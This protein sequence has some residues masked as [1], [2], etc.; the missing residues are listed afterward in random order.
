MDATPSFSCAPQQR[1]NGCRLAR[2]IAPCLAVCLLWMTPHSS[3]GF[4]PTISASGSD[5]LAELQ[6]Q[7]DAYLDEVRHTGRT[8]PAKLA[9]LEQR[10]R[11][12]AEGQ[13]GSAVLRTRVEVANLL[14]I[15]G[16]STE[17]AA[18]FQAVGEEA[19]RHEY[20]DV[21]FDAWIGVIR[22]N[23]A[24]TQNEIDHAYERAIAAAGPT[25]TRRQRHD[26]A[27]FHAQILEARGEP[28][29]AL[30]ESLESLMNAER[31]DD[32][33]FDRLTTADILFDIA[34]PCDHGKMVD[35]RT[36]SD[37]EKDGWEAC[38]RAVAAAERAYGVTL[39][40]AQTQGWGSEFAT[41]QKPA[42][43]FLAVQINNNART[44][45]DGAGGGAGPNQ[46][47]LVNESFSAGPLSPQLAQ[48][49]GAKIQGAIA[50]GSDSP[51]K[52]Y[53][54][55]LNESIQGNRAEALPYFKQAATKL[56]DERKG[57]F[58]PLRRGTVI[59]GRVEI[60]QDLALALLANGDQAA[61]FDVFE[62]FRSRGLN[63]LSAASLRANT[64]RERE[65]LAALVGI[66]AAEN[67]R[68]VRIRERIVSGGDAAL[69]TGEHRELD[70]DRAARSRL[71]SDAG[72]RRSFSN[73]EF[74][75]ARLADLKRASKLSG[76]PVVLYWTT[77][78]NVVVWIVSPAGESRVRTVLLPD[79]AL[80]EL[81]RRVLKSSSAADDGVPL[82]E[83]AA[84]QLHRHLLGP[85]QDLLAGSR[86]MIVP[87]GALTDLPF[88]ALLDP[89]TKRYAVEKWAISYAPNATIA[90]QMLTQEAPIGRDVRAIVDARLNAIT[91]EVDRIS[92]IPAFKV[93]AVD[94]DLIETSRLA[95]LA[96]EANIVHVLVHG[97]ANAYEPTLFQ[98]GFSKQGKVTAAQLLAT[99][100][101]S[102][103]LV[104]F[105]SCDSGEWVSSTSNEIHGL[106]WVLLV[107][108]ARNAIVSRW[109]ISS[110]SNADWMQWFYTELAKGVAPAQAAASASRRMIASSHGRPYYWAAM[111][112]MGR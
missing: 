57:F 102:T 65:W 17:S 107:G 15:E 76:T 106:P 49:L 78:V 52:L 63:E 36:T 38:R 98:L 4:T 37:A 81:V 20:R 93:K 30:V 46:S 108:G 42:L 86:L 28:D 90:V 110:A 33:F 109:P 13:T 61:A 89:Q 58:D 18:Q 16:R 74:Q 19:E 92:T 68:L 71:L 77:K 39:N 34:A 73:V 69:S 45:R 53:L 83:A 67:A 103:Q 75:S 80:N 31:P 82:D 22:A 97:S 7:R 6:H 3:R 96:G 112:V 14:R 85:F 55:G 48:A 66:E 54:Q 70:E 84:A 100:W 51:R 11:K 94:A 91:Q 72:I 87:Q 40:L 10:L 62:S 79:F 43:N 47:V 25:P 1:L 64:A 32:Q 44:E 8:D 95:D 23:S 104:V 41:A 24:G 50:G 21:A 59:E 9:L 111:R 35:A 29:A 56:N 12:L 101:R 5:A 26:L 60:L 2:C 88:E 99:P 27:A 105:S